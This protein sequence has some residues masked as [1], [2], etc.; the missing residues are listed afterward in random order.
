[1]KQNYGFQIFAFFIGS[2]FLSL[3]IERTVQANTREEGSIIFGM[4]L[5][6]FSIVTSMIKYLNRK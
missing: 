2:F 3:G 6:G 1:M 4:L 5:I